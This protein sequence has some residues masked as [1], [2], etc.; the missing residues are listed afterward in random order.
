[1]SGRTDAGK[2]ERHHHGISG[3][4]TGSRC[5]DPGIIVDAFSGLQTPCTRDWSTL[6]DDD[7]FD[8][9]ECEYQEANYRIYEVLAS[10]VL[11][12]SQVE[13]AKSEFCEE[14]SELVD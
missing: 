10:T 5:V 2:Y 6:E 3:D 13:K 11:E 9:N 14:K 4:I 8:R 7:E 1:M 12:Y